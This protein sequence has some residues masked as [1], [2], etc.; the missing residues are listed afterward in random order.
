MAAVDGEINLKIAGS[1]ANDVECL[2]YRMKGGEFPIRF[3]LSV[4]PDVDCGILR[5]CPYPCPAP[6][7]K[8]GETGV[9]VNVT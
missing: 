6:M 2:K 8:C 3:F 5:R 9:L 4:L 1:P 7:I